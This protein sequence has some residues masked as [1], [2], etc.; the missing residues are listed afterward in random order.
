MLA[1]AIALSL[2]VEIYNVKRKKRHCAEMLPDECGQ[3]SGQIIVYYPGVLLLLSR[4]H[5]DKITRLSCMCLVVDANIANLSTFHLFL[6]P[7]LT[8]GELVVNADFGHC[9]KSSIN[10]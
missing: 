5:K 8:N 4:L 10:C 1:F 7:K 9:T 2:T 6:L 3:T